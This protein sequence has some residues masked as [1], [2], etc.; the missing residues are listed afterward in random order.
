MWTKDRKRRIIGIILVGFIIYIGLVR[1]S[2][3]VNINYIIDQLFY[4]KELT[5]YHSMYTF[6]VPL[7]VGGLMKLKWALTFVFMLLNLGASYYILKTLFV[8][9]K[10]TIRLLLWGY[11]LLFVLSAFIFA[12]GKLT[13]QNELG[14]TLSRRFM[15]VLQSPVPLMVTAAVH[16]LFNNNS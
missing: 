11:L 14:Y 15:G 8:E 7:G 12:V 13:G 6:L 16:I 1:D 2:L 5:Y 3:F 4:N 10:L 9:S